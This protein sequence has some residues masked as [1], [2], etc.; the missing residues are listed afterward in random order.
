MSRRGRAG[1]P[2]LTADPLARRTRTFFDATADPTDKKRGHSK[3]TVPLERL[4]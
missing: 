1:L 3:L 2:W 4:P